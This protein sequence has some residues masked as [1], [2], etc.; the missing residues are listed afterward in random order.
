M[1]A[2]RKPP[3]DAALVAA[4]LIGACLWIYEVFPLWPVDLFHIQFAAYQW[5][6]GAPER[7]YAI[8]SDTSAWVQHYDSVAVARG[9]TEE[10]VNLHYYAP[11]VGALLAPFSDVPVI[12]WQNAVFGLDVS[13][14]FVMAWQI[15]ILCRVAVT[16]RTL[17]WALALVLFCY[18]YM[19]A[20]A[21]VQIGP[22]LAAALWAG[23]LG[24]RRGRAA[25]AGVAVG[26]IATIK[27]F[28]LAVLVFPA[29]RRNLRAVVAGVAL[30][31]GTFILSV[32]I[33]GVD[34]HARWIAAVRD[35]DSTTWPYYGN[36]SISGWF[37]R[38]VLGYGILDNCFASTPVTLAVRWISAVIIGGV[39]I[40]L[41]WRVRGRCPDEDF[42]P[43][44]GLLLSGLILCL[45]IAWEHYWVFV[46]PALGWAIREVW[47]GR[48][49]PA[50]RILLTCAAF[51]FLA[52]LRPFYDLDD[53]GRLFSGSHTAGMIL[54]WIW[55]VRRVHLRNME[56]AVHAL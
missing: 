51:F 52:P 15:L 19:V 6:V 48:D 13:M 25:T 10:T 4:L 28:P 14:L 26:A 42:A 27:L 44:A 1:A 12:W 35:L 43:Q 49:T 55:F 9:L 2:R 24:M 17:G 39:T 36:Q 20:A 23:L 47:Q 34:I 31:A 41:L 8:M 16:P 46:L 54:L 32:L 3:S 37:V 5:H 18:P 45:G 53:Y 22:I 38:A 30:F 33:L 11:F 56:N 40:F 7:I 29:L 21:V 50:G